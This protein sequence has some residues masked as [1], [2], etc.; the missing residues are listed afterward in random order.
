MSN[1]VKWQLSRYKGKQS[2]GTCPWCGKKEHWKPYVDECGVPFAEYYKDTRFKDLAATVGRC[3]S[4]QC[5]PGNYPPS[6]FFKETQAGVEKPKDY[7]PPP[8]P[9]TAQPLPWEWVTA[10]LLPYHS[11]FGQY[12]RDVAKLPSE[13]LD[14]AMRDYYVG[15]TRDGRIIYW[16]IGTDGQMRDGKFMAYKTDGHRD[17]DIKPRWARESD[18]KRRYPD[19]R[20]LERVRLEGMTV[21]RPMFGSHL[22]KDERYKDKPV[23]IVEGEKSALIGAVLQPAFLWLAS[24][25]NVIDVSKLATAMIQGRRLYFF[26]DMDVIQNPEPE[27]RADID[28]RWKRFYD[29][30][31]YA[32]YRVMDDWILQE[33]KTPKDDVGDILLR[34]YMEGVL[35]DEPQHAPTKT[36]K[37]YA[38][39]GTTETPKTEEEAVADAEPPSRMD[40]LRDMVREVRVIERTLGGRNEA[41]RVLYLGLDLELW[42]EAVE[43]GF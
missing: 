7:K 10:S 40:R 17:H 23:A 5:N 9:E 18:I 30:L 8:P 25:T 29:S 28:A 2:K 13:A 42:N 12:L 43:G 37:S 19:K 36:P 21:L 35:K 38:E 31:H 15:A 11:T 3:D 1:E 27:K 4:S 41:L 34:A 39:P 22:L 33:H 32:N 24:G 26:R 14:T 20:N 16:M 6:Q